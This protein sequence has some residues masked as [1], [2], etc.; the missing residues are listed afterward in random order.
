MKKN[1]FLF[2]MILFGI[3]TAFGQT[4]AVKDELTVKEKMLCKTWTMVSSEQFGVAEQATAA[5]KKDGIS[6][7]ENRTVTLTREGKTEQGTWKTNKNQTYIYISIDNSKDKILFKLISVSE[8]EL[9][10][11]YQDPE[12]IRTAYTFAASKK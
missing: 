2:S 7:S 10:Y 6:F 11:E 1:I 8:N 3:H 9:V 5:E 12:L 4:T